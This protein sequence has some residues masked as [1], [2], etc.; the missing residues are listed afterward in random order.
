MSGP[1]S[2]NWRLALPGEA[3]Y[4][5]EEAK[6]LLRH[7]LE[8]ITQF[9]KQLELLRRREPDIHINTH[10]DQAPFATPDVASAIARELNNRYDIYIRLRD[11][12]DK[13]KAHAAMRKRAAELMAT[14][15]REVPDLAAAMAQQR[16]ALQQRVQV[17]LQ[18]LDADVTDA[19]RTDIEKLAATC[20][21]TADSG[22]AELLLGE[23][24]VTL[25]HLN[26]TA[27]MA[28]RRLAEQRAQ[29][30]SEARQMIR[31]L[32]ALHHV[33]RDALRDE[34]VQVASG[35][36]PFHPDLRQRAQL[37]FAAAE[38]AQAGII[39]KDVLGKLGYEV[40]SDFETLLAEGGSNFFQRSSWGEYHCRLTVDAQRQHLNFDMVRYGSDS[41]EDMDTALRDREMEQKWC[42]EVPQLLA[43]LTD[44]GVAVNLTRKLAPGRVA[45]QVIN[46]NRLKPQQQKR[47]QEQPLARER[48]LNR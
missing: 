45:L 9:K 12:V 32:G 23:L 5:F 35:D 29:E 10:L 24:R 3:G 14:L 34:L 27:R 37:A 21:A 38:K 8:C 20:L 25:N 4:S 33:Y 30:A 11:E 13:A 18:T 19:S 46:D 15:K 28:R 43:Q 42:R 39:L 7:Y 26:K 48:T 47:K 16:D 17:L 22:R 6:A 36:A 40:Q 2:G 1:K 31:Q 41:N 44:A